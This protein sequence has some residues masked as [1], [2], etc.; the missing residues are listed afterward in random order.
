M[1]R[2]TGIAGAVALFVGVVGAIPLFWRELLEAQGKCDYVSC[3]NTSTAPALVGFGLMT[4]VG[5]CLLGFS[6]RDLVHRRRVAPHSHDN[7]VAVRPKE[8]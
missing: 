6:A 1:Y 2:V 7:A 5:I 3:V 4:L 8:R